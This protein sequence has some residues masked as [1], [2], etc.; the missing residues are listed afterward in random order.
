LFTFGITDQALDPDTLFGAF[1]FAT[2]FNFGKPAACKLHEPQIVVGLQHNTHI[3]F[4][5]SLGNGESPFS[6]GQKIISPCSKKQVALSTSHC[7]TDLL[8][9]GTMDLSEATLVN[10]GSQ[11]DFKR[12]VSLL[13]GKPAA[14]ITMMFCTDDPERTADQSRAAVAAHM[15]SVDHGRDCY[16]NTAW[17]KPITERQLLYRSNAMA[18]GVESRKRSRAEK[19]C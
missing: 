4:A 19:Q 5:T 12:S 10:L 17:G 14:G 2:S 9:A 1:Y 11:G 8:T 18:A 7:R 3:C 16:T 15:A 6:D 13:S